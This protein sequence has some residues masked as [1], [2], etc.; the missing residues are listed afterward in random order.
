MMKF[1]IKVIAVLLLGFWSLL[2]GT[3][4]A[5][6]LDNQEI[7]STDPVPGRYQAGY[8]LYLETC[9]S[10]HLPIPPGVLPS[11]TWKKLLEQ[12]DNHYGTNLTGINRLTQR[13]LWDYLSAFSRPLAIDEPVP[14]YT[15]QSR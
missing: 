11:E 14:L 12:P 3:G 2:L 7:P 10:C 13:L 4:L 1:T 8:E 6:A 9:S 5:Y 15:E